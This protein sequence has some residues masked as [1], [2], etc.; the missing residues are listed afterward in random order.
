MPEV[1][2]QVDP[3]DASPF[4]RVRQLAQRAG[5][6]GFLLALL[7]AIL[8]AYLWPHFGS[9]DGPLPLNQIANYGVS[10]IFF[11]YGLRLSPEKLK[12]GLSNWRLH[13]VVQTTTFL[14]FPLLL[15]AARPFFDTGNQKLLWL[16]GFYLAA[17]P[18][19][20]SSSVVMVS[21]AGGNLPAAIFNASISSLL[22]VFVTP[23]WMALY[24]P[25]G[26]HNSSLWGTIGNLALQ[27]LLPVVVGVLLH[28]WLSAWAKRYD[29]QTRY[30]D[31]SIILLIVYTSFCESFYRGIFQGY[32]LTSILLLGVL[33]L[34]LFFGVY[35]WILLVS[36]VLGFEKGDTITALFCGSKKSLVQGTVMSKVLFPDA[37]LAGIVLLPLMMYHALQILIASI[38]AQA[39]GRRAAPEVPVP[40][41]VAGT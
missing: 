40:E 31:Q 19:T 11:F 22:G 36:K 8:L 9:D 2:S 39:I 7:G 27:V 33:L 6:D 14:V 13:L 28:R 38:I 23:I 32:Q 35:A 10:I 30:L 12:A 4:T 16:G 37:R 41:P 18:S 25:N 29:K 20:V 26:G 15:I 17:L 24:L 3:S 1:K 5:L 34:A 21:I